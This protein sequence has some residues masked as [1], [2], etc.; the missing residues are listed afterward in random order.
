MNQLKLFQPKKDKQPLSF[1]SVTRRMS[2]IT[3]RTLPARYNDGVYRGR[4]I[5]WSD[6]MRLAQV[7]I[8]HTPLGYDLGWYRYIVP[9]EV[10]CIRQ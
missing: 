7:I 5:W 1:P 4:L 10:I 6:R 9:A 8:T 2:R 3:W